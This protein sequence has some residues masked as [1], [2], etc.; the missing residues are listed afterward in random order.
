M[1]ACRID[2]KGC[3][4]RHERVTDRAEQS[5]ELQPGARATRRYIEREESS[6]TKE[7]QLDVL[8]RL[9]AILLQ[10]LL[11]LLAARDGG[12][13][14]GGRGAAH[15]DSAHGLARYARQRRASRMLAARRR[16]HEA[17]RTR[18]RAHACPGPVGKRSGA[19]SHTTRCA[20][21]WVRERRARDR[22]RLNE[23]RRGV[24]P[25]TND[26]SR[27][28]AA[29]HALRT[30]PSPPPPPLAAQRRPTPCL[31]LPA[32]R[33]YDRSPTANT[34]NEQC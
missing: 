20:V 16:A 12:A 10:V 6:I 1:S 17:P 31:H 28:S 23:W 15:G 18:E 8:G 19:T 32:E 13:L 11:D 21:S 24:G 22:C 29:P 9:D 26:G 4:C 25:R 5:I 3:R 33:P 7:Q 30:L 34:A 14:L 2:Y 27:S